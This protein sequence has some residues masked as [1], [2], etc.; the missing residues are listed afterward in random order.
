MLTADM[1]AGQS[2]LMAQEIA[3]Q[4]RGFHLALIVNFRS[5]LM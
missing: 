3:E 5:Q 1:C 4:K 2:Q